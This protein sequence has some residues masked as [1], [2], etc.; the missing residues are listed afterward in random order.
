MWCVKSLLFSAEIWP[1]EIQNK[2]RCV[3]VRVGYKCIFHDLTSRTGYLGKH[4][5]TLLYC[6]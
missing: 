5:I 3:S 1:L 6:I 4:E 2:D